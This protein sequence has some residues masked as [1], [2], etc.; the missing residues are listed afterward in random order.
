MKKNYKTIVIN[1]LLLVLILTNVFFLDRWV[2]PY[3]SI[4][5][6][7]SNYGKIF[8]TNN[9]KFG[10]GKVLIG[11]IY[12]TKKGYKFSTEKKIVTNGDIILK[13]SCLLK[14]IFSVKSDTKDYSDKLL[15]GFNGAFLYLTIG[16]AIST[17]FSL[18]ILKFNK[19]L[20]ENGFQNIILFNS[21]LLFYM[22]SILYLYN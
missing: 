13:R 1:A 10:S 21:L 6:E 19:G 14:N 22:L 3:E 11:Y 16:L 9:N 17:I 18:V 20:S 2:L 15:S 4:D 12:F 8:K 5:D 7:I